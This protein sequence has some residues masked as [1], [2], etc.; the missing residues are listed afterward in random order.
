MDNLAI[1]IFVGQIK[2]LHRDLQMLAIQAAN[3][4]PT[5]VPRNMIEADRCG[6]RHAYNEALRLVDAMIATL[7]DLEEES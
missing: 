1:P 7:Q 2:K 5:D 4:A 3:T 6:Q